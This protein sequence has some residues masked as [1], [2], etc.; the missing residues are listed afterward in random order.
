[1]RKPHA[2]RRFVLALFGLSAVALAEPSRRASATRS[3]QQAQ[4][5][6]AASPPAPP[7][8]SVCAEDMVLVQGNHCA[9][10]RERCLEWSD[11][12][13]RRCLRFEEPALCRG[14]RRPLRFCMDRFEW[15][16]RP[17][18]EPVVMVTFEEAESQCRNRGRRL[19]T[20]S[21]W[22][23]ACSG[24]EPRPYPYGYERD[25]TAC[26]IDHHAQA[27]DRRLLHNRATRFAEARRVYEAA[28]SGSHPRCASVFGAMDLTG[29]VDEWVVNET[30]TPFRSS[31][32][33]GFWGRVRTR[34]RAT[35]REH[36]ENF[37]YYQIGFRCCSDTTDAPPRSQRARH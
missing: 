5:T 23:F 31:L 32:M 15:P 1:M 18:E 29:N 12:G 2:T 9:D 26:V 36:G 19:C 14:P 4:R 16:N 24:E 35:T 22:A 6:L 33:G 7:A 34:C 17:G 28:P 21:E 10:P 37:R 20:E 13:R 30:G 8:P 3:A 27:P 25:D 11:D